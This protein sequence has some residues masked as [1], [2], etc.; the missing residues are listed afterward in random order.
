MGGLENAALMQ[1]A[2]VACKLRKSAV[3][4]RCF[5]QVGLW[6]VRCF[7]ETAKTDLTRLT[8]IEFLLN[9]T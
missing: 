7:F 1:S 8:V 9:I 2:E 5:F 4:V 3:G 6:G